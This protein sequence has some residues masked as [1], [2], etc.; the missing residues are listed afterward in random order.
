MEKELQEDLETFRRELGPP[1]HQRFPEEVEIAPYLRSLPLAM[2]DCWRELGFAAWGGG[3]VWTVWPE[4][5]EDVLEE[6]LR[7]TP[8]ADQDRFHVLACSAF[9]VMYLWGERSGGSVIIDPHTGT[10]YHSR[11]EEAAFRT[12][13]VDFAVGTFFAM[14][15]GG[16]C[17]Y[18]DARG[19]PLFARARERLGPL[20]PG[21]IFTFASALALGGP[22][23]LEAL[24]RDPAAEHLVF[25]AQTVERTVV[26]L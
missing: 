26:S 12:G 11:L 9:G 16:R 23:T 20:E 4:P 22:R 25:L 5:W 21:E 19:E 14:R 8:L 2:L 10:F 15:T 7:D 17:D 6:W 3:L 24:T 18:T 13:K 1:E